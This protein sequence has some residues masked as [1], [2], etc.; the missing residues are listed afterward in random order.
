MSNTDYTIE[1]FI[2]DLATDPNVPNYVQQSATS[3]IEEMNAKADRRIKN[4][5]KRAA[6]TVDS[7]IP[8]VKVY[9]PETIEA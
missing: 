2:T 9:M 8:R 6:K 3:F 7:K 5:M 4:R 1:E